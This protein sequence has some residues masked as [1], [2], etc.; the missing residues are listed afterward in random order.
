MI[1]PVPRAVI[2]TG[3]EWPAGLALLRGLHAAGA[4]PV[5]AVSRRS[6]LARWSRAAARTALIPD[7]A[8]PAAHAAALASLAARHG[9][10]LVL[11]GSEASLLALAE[12]RGRFGPDDVVAVPELAVVELALDKRALAPL[13][14]RAG[15]AVPPTEEHV[16]GRRPSFGFPAVVKPFSSETRDA[17]GSLR[18]VLVRVIADAAELESAVPREGA[19]LQ[20]FVAGP[21]RTVNGVAWEGRV[22][23]SVHQRSERT[24]PEGAGVFTYGRTIAADPALEAACGRLVADL[25]WS[26][27]F[28]LQFLEPHGGPPALIDVNPR[29]Y[30][31]LA[32]AQGAG[33]NLAGIWLELLR[34]GDPAA[35]PA[36]GGVRF[37]SEIDDLRALRTLARAGRRGEALRA[38]FPRAGTVH[39]LRAPGDPGPLLREIAGLMRS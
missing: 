16:P 8:D 11:P 35:L 39:A 34:G 31:S 30:Y 6:S 29:A 27:L 13:A 22:V 7:A 38:A 21:L 9:G 28:N 12:H 24:W 4:R 23:A 32:L 15:L 14:R 33:V 2:A 10:A 18:R 1:P 5:A 26:G 19:L 25:G 3:G 17:A 37:R 36:R 20:A